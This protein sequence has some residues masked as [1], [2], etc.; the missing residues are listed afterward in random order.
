MTARGNG[1]FEAG[2]GAGAEKGSGSSLMRGRTS[3]LVG[4]V[5]VV[6]HV[7]RFRARALRGRGLSRI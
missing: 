6:L 3:R 1:S 5:R 7:P 4:V 2:E